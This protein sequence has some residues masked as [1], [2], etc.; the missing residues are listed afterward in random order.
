MAVTDPVGDLLTRIRN[1]QMRRK[2]TTSTPASRNLWPWLAAAA[3]IA[4]GV[5]QRERLTARFHRLWKALHP[6]DRTAARKLLSAC[7]RNDAPAASAAWTAWRDT[8]PAGYQPPPDL[9]SALLAMQRHRFGPVPASSWQG[10]D[11]A[12]AFQQQTLAP[13]PTQREVS[14]LPPLNP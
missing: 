1:A 11:L 4:I 2:S 13:S 7:R 14:P 6:P 8:R 10:D 5:W 3:W 12:R 9:Q